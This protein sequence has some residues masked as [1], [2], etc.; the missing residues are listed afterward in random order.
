M[1]KSPINSPI[2]QRYALD[3]H[4]PTLDPFLFCAHHHDRF[5]AGNAQSGP[6]TS[7][8]GRQLGQDF[9]YLDGWNMYHGEQVSGFP[10]HPHRGFETITIVRE[11]LVDHADSMGAAG[12]YG[13]G[14]VQWM[15]AGKGVQHSEMFPLVH[16]DKVNPLTL[17]QVWLNLPASSKMTDPNFTMFWQQDIPVYE[18]NGVR[19]EVIAG[20]LGENSALSPPPDSW[21]SRAEHQVNIWTIELQ[22][23]ACWKLPA[24]DA[25]VNRMLYFHEGDELTLADERVNSG[26]GFQLDASNEVTISNGASTANLLL[27]QGKPINEPVAQHGPFVMNNREELQQAFTDYQQTMFGGW[28][29]PSAEPVH[30]GKPRFATFTDGHEEFPDASG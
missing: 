12:R 22:P 8:E 17:F 3:F 19:I 10:V 25:E 23:G 18:Q 15:T 4:W 27:L 14:D 6:A 29:W 1:A 28:P 16:E 7:L 5:P 24:A 2:L 30:S 13:H 11:G 9:A 21:A 26:T 20:Q